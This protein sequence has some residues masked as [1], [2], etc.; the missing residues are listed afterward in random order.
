MTQKYDSVFLIGFGGPTKGCCLRYEECPGEAFCYVE[1]IVGNR[2]GDRDRIEEVSEHYKHFNGVSPFVFY[3]QKQAGALELSLREKGCELPVF[4]GYRFW[5]P[6]VKDT[7]LEMAQNGYQRSVGIVLA[8]HKTKISWDAYL[9]EVKKAKEEL[10]VKNVEIDFMPMDWFANPGYIGALSE[11]TKETFDFSMKENQE[12]SKLI[13]TAHSIP[14]S[15][16][17]DS[18]YEEDVKKTASEIAKVLKIETYGVAFQSS[19]NVPPGTWLEPDILDLIEGNARTDIKNIVVVPVGFI[20][21]HVEVLYDL[22]FES[23]AYA[24]SL[25]LKYFRVPTVGTHPRFIHMLAGT[26]SGFI[27]GR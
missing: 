15:M 12:C 25:G 14:V 5:N 2:S 19:P 6:F 4:T 11:L 10:G 1:N 26:V 3:S 7:L 16:A 24:E 27:S 13:F 22:D 8:P 18:T 23:K 20:C 21:D 17:K 9:N